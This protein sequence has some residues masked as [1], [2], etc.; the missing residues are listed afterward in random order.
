MGLSHIFCQIRPIY[1]SHW[2]QTAPDRLQILGH[3]I[4][5]IVNCHVQRLR[6][7]VGRLGQ[8]EVKSQRLEINPLPIFQTCSKF[9]LVTH[10]EYRFFIWM[11]DLQGVHQG[12]PRWTDRIGFF[13]CIRIPITHYLSPLMYYPKLKTFCAKNLPKTSLPKTLR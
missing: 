7:S 2:L 5:G 9:D 11:P 3:M 12:F 8:L 4:V 10:N 1:Q 13:D 6:P